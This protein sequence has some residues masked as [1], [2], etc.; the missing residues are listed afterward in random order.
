MFFTILICT[1]YVYMFI[2][3]RIPHSKFQPTFLDSLKFDNLVHAYICTFVHTF[4]YYFP[5]RILAC[6][7]IFHC[8]WITNRDVVKVA[9]TQWPYPCMYIH[10][11]IGMYIYILFFV[12]FPEYV[13]TTCGNSGRNGPSPQQCETAYKDTL[14]NTS[15]RVL[16]RCRE[17]GIPSLDSTCDTALYVSV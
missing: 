8:N 7:S 2:N 15:V 17:R 16:D 1:L 11:Y 13:F 14:L 3:R 10:T 4:I 6:K 5:L 9:F 12:N